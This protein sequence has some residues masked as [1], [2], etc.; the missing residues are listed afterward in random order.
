MI[1]ITIYNTNTGIIRGVITCPED[2]KELQ[3]NYGESY[4]VGNYKSSEYIIIDGE[5]TLKPD[6]TDAEKNEIALTK[7][8]IQRNHLLKQCDWTQMPD[9]PL[10]TVDKEAWATYRQSLRDLPS[11]VDNTVTNISDVTFPNPPN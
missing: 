1:T 10:S 8:R 7:L 5:P 9:S 3:C 11:T 2:T 6:K 4:I